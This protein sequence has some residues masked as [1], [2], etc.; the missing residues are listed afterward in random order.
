MK[1]MKRGF[2]EGDKKFIREKFNYYLKISE[3]KEEINFLR[4][5]IKI[6][7]RKKCR[8]KPEWS[9]VHTDPVPSN[10]VYNSK[11]KRIFLID[12][13]KGRID[14]PSFDLCAIFSPVMAWSWE[15]ELSKKE[16]T[17][18]IKNYKLFE[19]DKHLKDKVRQR[20][21]FMILWAALWVCIRTS[22]IKRGI[23][24][25]SLISDMEIYRSFKDKMF[26]E[27]N[28]ILKN[29]TIDI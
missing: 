13:E 2:I 14:D 26:N 6:L 22:E 15:R 16:K 25:K 19:Y 28:K 24:E 21:P 29:G 7:F 27:I 5:V 11:F 20:Y 1:F 9:F 3:N 10:M 8:L 4:K 23:I 17:I 12:W 18:F